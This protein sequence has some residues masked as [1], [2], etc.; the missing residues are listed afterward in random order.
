M[1]KYLF[2]FLFLNTSFLRA[3]ET[4]FTYRKII[5]YNKLEGYCFYKDILAL[6]S[7][8]LILSGETVDSIGKT[9]FL[10][11]L[12]LAG[13]TLLNVYNKNRSFAKFSYYT[14]STLFVCGI[15]S[16]QLDSVKKSYLPF[17]AVYDTLLKEKTYFEFPFSKDSTYEITGVQLDSLKNELIIVGTCYQAITDNLDSANYQPYIIK[18]S[19]RNNQFI[20]KKIEIK[21]HDFY[22]NDFVINKTNEIYLLGGYYF[23]KKKYLINPAIIKLDAIGNFEFLKKYFA[24]DRYLPSPNGYSILKF[25]NNGFG[26][27]GYYNGVNNGD[28]SLFI[29][30]NEFGYVENE[31]VHQ[32]YFYDD[33]INYPTC[34]KSYY[35]ALER[36][37]DRIINSG[38]LGLCI[39]KSEY[40]EYFITETNLEGDTLFYRRLNTDYLKQGLF[41]Y[42]FTN[43]ISIISKGNLYLIGSIGFDNVYPKSVIYFIDSNVIKRME[44][45]SSRTGIN[46]TSNSIN[47]D[48]NL[49]FNNNSLIIKNVSSK[50]LIY[51]RVLDNKG[52]EVYSQTDV[53]LNNREL[54]IPLENWASGLYFVNFIDSENRMYTRKFIKTK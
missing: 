16:S 15:Y 50:N 22:V 25:K 33:K 1:H 30:I 31:K 37:K 12:N 11:K 3:Q 38:T 4:N 34:F 6:Q 5:D 14:D 52:I 2:L 53:E 10:S 28:G 27:Y 36:F 43:P 20:L 48:H 41:F 26:I 39:P 54:E 24:G 19:L 21:D 18:Y 32:E 47:S 42:T 29:K 51:I 13:D 46:E 44:K 7:G 8:N 23:Q 17:I 40:S 45:E 9:G 49:V 35:T